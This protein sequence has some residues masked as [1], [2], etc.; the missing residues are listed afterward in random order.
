[1]SYTDC[2]FNGCFGCYKC[3][4]KP[5]PDPEAVAEFVRLRAENRALRQRLA[6]LEAKLLER[7]LGIAPKP[8]G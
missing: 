3:A 8:E 5:P 6:D 2:D 7:H 4:P 1:M